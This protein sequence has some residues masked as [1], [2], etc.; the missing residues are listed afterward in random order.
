MKIIFWTFLGAVVLAPFPFGMVYILFQAFFACV[1]MTLLAGY[2]IDRFKK[3]NEPDVSLKRIWPE[4]LGF[5]LVLGWGMLQLSSLTPES[6]HHPLWTDTAEVL[7][8]DIKGSISLARGAGFESIMRLLTYGAVFFLA[9]QMGRDRTRAE[10]LI[11]AVTIAGTVYAIYGLV[12]YFGNLEM[13]LWVETE[14]P[15]RNVSGTFVNRNNFAAYTGLVLLCAVGLYMAGFFKVIRSGR[16]GR[17]K[18]FHLIQQAFVRGAPLLSFIL[19]LLT[20][21]FL[22][23]SRAGVTASLASMLVLIVFLGMMTRMHSRAYRVLTVSVLAVLLGV[24][25]LSGEGWLDRL[26]AVDLER[27][28]RLKAYEQAWQAIK[29]SPWIGYGLGGFRQTFF[30]FADESTNNFMMAHNDWLEMIY[31]LGFPA[32]V[33][34]F[35]VIAVPAMRC[36]LGFFLRRRDHIYPLIGFCACLLVGLHSLVDFSLQIPAVAVTFSVLLGVG[37]SQSWSSLKPEL[38]DR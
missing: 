29:L 27:D 28:G 12:S 10:I 8:V 25:F 15:I 3:C 22:T 5:F 20:A 7:D 11:W 13:I 19:V 33:L 16:T 31:E 23:G 26:L 30:M 36:L 14:S 9:L 17:D 24:F 35:M 18:I 4:M 21:L 32:A 6:W 38:F 34:W 1:M 37:V 2:C